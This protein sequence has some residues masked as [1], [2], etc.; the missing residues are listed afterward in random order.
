MLT[1]THVP[2]PRLRETIDGLEKLCAK[3]EE[4]WPADREFFF[5]DPEGVHRLFYCCKACY[6]EQL[7]PRRLERSPATS[8]TPFPSLFG[9]RA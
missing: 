8:I 2:H 4:W 1:A 6:R 9:A 3:C 7:D 5:S